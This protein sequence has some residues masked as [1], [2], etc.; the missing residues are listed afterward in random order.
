MS[1]NYSKFVKGIRQAM[2]DRAAKFLAKLDDCNNQE[3]IERCCQEEK[4]DF[5]ATFE[6]LNTRASYMTQYRN[7]IKEWQQHIELTEE[8]SS[9]KQIKT[10]IVRQH[11]SLFYMNYP[12]EMHDERMEPTK[13]KKDEQR[14]NL[15][16]ISCVD[17]YVEIVEVL[18][19]SLD[20]R[21]LTVGLIAATG[22]RI[23]EI[24]STASFSQIGQFEVSFE[25]QLK[26]KGET[27]EYAAFTLVESALVIDG[28]LKLRRMAE[29][30][31]MKHWNLA[32]IDS[33]KNNTVNR[34]VKQHFSE[35]IDP[36]H[37]EKEL[38]SKNL[39][40]AYA[41][42]AIYLFCPSNHS[43]SLFIKERLGHTSDAT[44]SNYEDYQIV[45]INGKQLPRG[46]W[47]ERINE[48][49]GKPMLVEV[50]PQL[51][52]TAAAKEVINDQEFLLYPDQL[53]RIEELIRLARI[54]KQ[55]EQGKLVKEVVKVVE[56]VK[57]VEKPVEV[58]KEV[59]KEVERIVE[60]PLEAIREAKRELEGVE[61]V[62]KVKAV[63]EVMPVEEV[64]PTTTRFEEMSN[65]ELKGCQAPGSA[66]EKIRR[67]VRAIKVYNEQQAEKKYQWS[68]N[69]STLEDLSGC[70]SKAVRE[71]L[72]SD[73]GRLQVADYNL[74]KGFG[75]QQNRGKGSI[76]EYVN[77]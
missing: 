32:E 45:D 72:D 75:F 35:L 52:M 40:A 3:E 66:L 28:I 74:E 10:G 54:G 30:K 6:S 12:R 71:Y 48:E 47:V 39:R 9:L 13:Q 38:S 62:E 25:G 57:E 76:K 63:E 46:V 29:I 73:E 36:P 43:E 77:W 17:R 18:L 26:A 2:R 19:K 7:A 11:Y 1:K 65:E 24:L 51:R 41:A 60:K 15:T 42:I 22:R 8:N 49:M 34:Y 67:S 21:E 5:E 27:G 23:S 33:G 50:R 59:V 31:E 37:G 70:H 56:V 53:S 20:Y 58:I 61:P 14:R 4:A 68:I 55:F 69:V 16:P 64:K 44:A